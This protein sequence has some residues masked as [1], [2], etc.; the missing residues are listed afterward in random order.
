MSEPLNLG[1]VSFVNSSWLGLSNILVDHINEFSKYKIQ[2]FTIN[3]DADFDYPCLIKRR[4]DLPSENP[5]TICY[6]KILASFDNVFDFGLI[7][8][9]DMIPLPNIDSI[10]DENLKFANYTYPVCAQHPHSPHKKPCVISSLNKVKSVLGLSKQINKYVY[11]SYL[12]SKSNFSFLRKCFDAC[13]YL[14]KRGIAPINSDETVLN[15]M[16]SELGDY[17]DIGHNYLPNYYAYPDFI[18]GKHD[19]E[20][21]K[22][23]TGYGCNLKFSI[24]HGCKDI[25]IAK[26]YSDLVKSTKESFKTTTNFFYGEK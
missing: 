9:G 13:L 10:M 18:S 22:N 3:C 7:L 14:E 26:Q 17:E 19:S 11:A 8:D 16:L 5:R 4:I 23:Y 25:G 21:I 1:Y 12:F 20:H 15:V 2:L 24:L 6:T